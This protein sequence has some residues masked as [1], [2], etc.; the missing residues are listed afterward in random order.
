MRT[1]DFSKLLSQVE[2]LTALQK[3]SL[4][5]TIE[6]VN[7]LASVVAVVQSRPL[8]CPHCRGERL[9]RHG[10]VSG[11]QRYKCLDCGK[12]FNAL[13]GTPLARLRHKDKWQSQVEVLRDGLSVPDAAARLGVAPST[14][15]RWRHRFLHLPRERKAQP[16]SGVVEA[17]ETYFLRSRKGQAVQGRRARSRGGRAR[18]RGA[19]D[20]HEPV[21]VV[22]NRSGVTEQFILERADK[23]HTL[24]ALA[25]VLAMDSVLCTDGGGALAAAAQHLGVEHHVLNLSSR[26]RVRGPWHIQNVNAYHSRLKHWIRRFRGIASSHLASYLAWFNILDRSTKTPRQPPPFLHQAVGV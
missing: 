7:E 13:T 11:L 2:H 6:E 1:R 14:A 22:R 19:N 9:I 10:R 23:P 17:D 15:F 12:T 21:L 16:L 20:E 8:S 25:S 18:K 5:R 4:R 3:E 26:L 24:A